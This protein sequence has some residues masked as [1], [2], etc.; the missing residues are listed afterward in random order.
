MLYLVNKA[1]EDAGIDASIKLDHDTFVKDESKWGQDPDGSGSIYG[2]DTAT[3]T[4]NYKLYDQA[5]TASWGIDVEVTYR[6][7]AVIV[8]WVGNMDYPQNEPTTPW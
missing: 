6:V 5:G 3:Y 8:S 1:L 2:G 4:A 7:N